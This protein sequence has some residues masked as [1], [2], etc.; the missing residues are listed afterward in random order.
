MAASSR[1]CLIAIVLAA[2][3]FATAGA[4]RAAERQT[5]L[6]PS[7]YELDLRVDFAAET[8]SGS[9]RVVLRNAGAQPVHEASFLLYRLMTVRAVRDERGGSIPFRQD[10]VAFED[11]PRK[12][13]NH[14]RVPLP[15]P[16]EPGASTSVVIE[17]AGYLAGYVETGSRYIKDRVDE[18]FTIIREDAE[19]YP[20]VRVPSDAANRAAG[21]PEFDYLARV[22]VPETHVVANGGALVE[23]SVRDGR[24]VF[25][26]RNLKPAWRMDFAIARF[27]LL[28]RPG[29]R[30]FYLP[31]DADGAARV[32][33]AA[34]A[35]LAL[36]QEWFG[37]LK[38]ASTFTVIE[39][40]DGWGS[41]TDV[42]SIIQAA[43]A[44]RDPKRLY[45]VYHEV[46]HLWNVKPLDRPS[47]RWNE[48]LASFLEDLARERLEGGPPL[49]AGAEQMARWLRKQA[50][51]DSRLRGVPMI[52]Y[53]QE[54]MTDYSYSVGML[55]FYALHRVVG[56]ETFIGIVGDA[57]RSYVETGVTDDGFVQHAKGRARQDLTPLFND[58]LYT[59][60]WL[61]VLS[62]SSK[63]QDLA[64]HYR[65]APSRGR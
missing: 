3:T 8:I 54:G 34:A 25:V 57:Y 37:P 45:E 27:G 59:T 18:E 31:G 52:R 41:Q 56:H 30:V 6:E 24:A 49:D 9:A 26:Y 17:Y 60:R 35:C 14:I 42:T 36:F 47:C 40:P 44:F 21:L 7:R 19:A 53:G 43:A 28:E 12:Q 65:S 58:W 39:I 15:V 64:A 32:L 23:R 63:V 5:W 11:K 46:S 55:M 48:G 50:G 13:V 62:G 38:Q 51:E 29:L 22:S 20:T 33:E 1:F 61:D 4:T 10:V 16:L 2:S